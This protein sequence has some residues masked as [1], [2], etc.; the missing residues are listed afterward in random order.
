LD[1]ERVQRDDLDWRVASYYL[2]DYPVYSLAFD[3]D[4]RPAY[5]FAQWGQ[6]PV[7]LTNSLHASPLPLSDKVRQLLL[8]SSQ[9][10]KVAGKEAG[11]IKAV[12]GSLRLLVEPVPGEKIT[13]AGYQFTKIPQ[14]PLSYLYRR[15]PYSTSLKS[16][17]REPSPSSAAVSTCK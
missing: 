13:F 2:P 12:S 7:P 8:I 10:D 9:L 17:W 4:V 15:S 11:E 16:Y 5:L 6:S 3:K 14:S 1:W